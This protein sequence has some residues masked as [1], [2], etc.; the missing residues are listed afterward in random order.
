MIAGIHTGSIRLDD[1]EWTAQDLVRLLA[2]RDALEARLC[3]LGPN[4]CQPGGLIEKLNQLRALVQR[5]VD[6]PHI[7][8]TI[9]VYPGST[10]YPNCGR[11]FAQRLLELIN[12]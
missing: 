10:C 2:E 11:C 4:A 1:R 12:A 8:H 7:V 6:M 3:G 9:P 5:H